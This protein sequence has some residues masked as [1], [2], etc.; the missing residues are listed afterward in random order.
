MSQDPKSG[1]YDV[2]GIETIDVIKAKLTKEQFEGFCLGNALKY[3]CRMMWKH[4]TYG[5]DIE[6]AM[7]YLNML[8]DVE[9]TKGRENNDGSLVKCA[10]C[11]VEYQYDRDVCPSCGCSAIVSLYADDV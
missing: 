4:S 6:K 10:S 1:Y 11:R 9:A 7:M 3:G 8:Q 2:G 5:R